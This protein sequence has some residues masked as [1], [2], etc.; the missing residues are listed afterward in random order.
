MLIRAVRVIDGLSDHARESQDVLVDGDRIV[1][2]EPHDPVRPVD[3]A[4]EIV[5][6]TG[7]TL[8]PGLIDAH[9]HYTFDPTEGLLPGDRPALG[10]R[11]PRRSGRACR[12]GTASRGHHRA[13]RGLDPEPRV[14]PA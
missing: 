7:R 1:A 5:D 10:C 14:R 3:R 13:G 6:G 8:L 2:I 12:P 11:H 4:V 9:A